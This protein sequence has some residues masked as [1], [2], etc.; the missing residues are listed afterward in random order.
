M[1]NLGNISTHSPGSVAIFYRHVCPLWNVDHITFASEQPCMLSRANK[2]NL[3][4][5]PTTVSQLIT[6]GFT[7]NTQCKSFLNFSL[8]GNIILVLK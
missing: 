3:P 1:Y 2:V 6:Q 7:F 4:S 5:Q 8:Q